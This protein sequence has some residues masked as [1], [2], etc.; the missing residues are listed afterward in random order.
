M[1][2]TDD[3]KPWTR[4]L[5]VGVAAIVVVALVIGGVVSAL[6]LGAARVTGIDESR[7]TATAR[8]SLYLPSG[9]PTTQVD[10]YPEP[11][12]QPEA[13]ASASPSSRPTPRR[14]VRAISLQV[15][16]RRVSAGQ[17]IN[18]TGAYKGAQGARLQVQRFEEGWVDFPVTVNVRSGR[19]ATYVTTSRTGQNRFRVLDPVSGR[20]SDAV[21]VTVG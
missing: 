20:T 19:F 8:P 6:A 10:E 2:G 16:P 17:R 12:G 7:P 4:L 18:L 14:K 11:E 1:A 3:D 9:E 13:T 15:L 5:L 21:R